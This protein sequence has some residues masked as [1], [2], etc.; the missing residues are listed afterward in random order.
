MRPWKR[1]FLWKPS[2]SGSMLIFGGVLFS[3]EVVVVGHF[4]V[5]DLKATTVDDLRFFFD[6]PFLLLGSKIHEKNHLPK[7]GR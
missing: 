7:K 3:S 6:Y 5:G 2:F 1:R 4:V